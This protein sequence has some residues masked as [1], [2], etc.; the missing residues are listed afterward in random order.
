MKNYLSTIIK[1]LLSTA[2]RIS[3]SMHIRRYE[4]TLVLMSCTFAVIGS[5]F[6]L[7]S[8]HYVNVHF[9]GRNVYLICSQHGNPWEKRDS[10]Q[11]SHAQIFEL[12]NPLIIC[13]LSRWHF[14]QSNKKK[15][16]LTSYRLFKRSCLFKSCN[17]TSGSMERFDS[18]WQQ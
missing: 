4:C 14:W 7:I 1:I 11:A 18:L 17:L 5:T 9:M 10:L 15:K 8:C 13:Q 2:Y 6:V 12:G 3:V 16:R